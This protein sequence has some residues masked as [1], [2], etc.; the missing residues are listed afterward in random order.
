MRLLF[1]MQLMLVRGLTGEASN[2]QVILWHNS[3]IYGADHRGGHHLLSTFG[4]H[5]MSKFSNIH[6][7]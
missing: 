3:A 4:G 1:Y 6:I 5:L 7:F 2:I